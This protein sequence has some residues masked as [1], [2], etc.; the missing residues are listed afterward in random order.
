MGSRGTEAESRDGSCPRVKSVGTK[1]VRLGQKPE[2]VG[3]G[4]GHGGCKW[5]GGVPCGWWGAVWLAGCSMW[6]AGCGV[7]EQASLVEDEV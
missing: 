3:G 1:G 5:A 7:C 4:P 2:G 6:L